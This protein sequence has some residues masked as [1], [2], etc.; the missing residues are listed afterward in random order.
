MKMEY[1]VSRIDASQDSGPYVYITFSD[2]DELKAGP[3]SLQ[4]V[5]A[6]KS[7][8]NDKSCQHQRH[9]NSPMYMKSHSPKTIPVFN[10]S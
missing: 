2:P 5:D 1:I 4:P 10:T 3:N 7:E 8:E 9:Y 6:D